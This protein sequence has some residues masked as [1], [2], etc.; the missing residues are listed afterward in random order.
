MPVAAGRLVVTS[1]RLMRHPSLWKE[2]V[3][4]IS[5][6]NSIKMLDFLGKDYHATLDK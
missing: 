1:H 2:K 6:I 3:T 4:F 5:P